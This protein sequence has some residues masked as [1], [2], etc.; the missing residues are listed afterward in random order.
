MRDKERSEGRSKGFQFLS[1]RF[2]LPHLSLL[3]RL[4]EPWMFPFFP[5]F[6]QRF[7]LLARFFLITILDISSFRTGP[8][9]CQDD[10]SQARDGN[11]IFH[12]TSGRLAT[13][14]SPDEQSPP[15]PPPYPRPSPSRYPVLSR[16][17][18]CGRSALFGAHRL[19]RKYESRAF[20]P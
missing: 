13:T 1:L 11:T 8:S 5:V 18:I 10:R 14:S 12:L 16:D 9:A 20:R 17:P 3:S 15:P 7:S 19:R 4:I 2:P 6:S